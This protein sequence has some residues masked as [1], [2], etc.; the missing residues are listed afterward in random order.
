MREVIVHPTPDVS[1]TVHDVPIPTPGP[2]EII[3]KVHVA[4]SNVKDWLHLTTLN[5]SCNSGDDIAGTVYT[6]GTNAGKSGEFVIGDRVAAFHPMLTDHGAFAEYAV[7]PMHTV[8]KIPDGLEFEEVATIPL[9]IM[10]AGLTLFRRQGLPP[11]WSPR[12]NSDPPT[13]LIIYGAGSA[14]GTFAVK[15]A[16]ASNIH[17]IVAIAGESTSHIRPLLDE[18]LGDRLF[19]YRVG[20]HALKELVDEHLK[21]TPCHHAFDAISAKGTWISVSQMLSPSTLNQKSFLSV[22]SGANK[23]DE[24]SIPEGISIIYTYVGTVHTGAYKASMPKQPL[25]QG[26]V[27]SDPEWAYVFYKYV[28]R[29]L[30]DRRLKGHPFV[31]VEGGLDGVG[32]G[33]RMLKEGKA[34]G[35]KFVFQVAK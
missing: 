32:K 25:D 22:V 10:T 7:A 2:D 34:R 1:A 4:G 8:F 33:L 17:P 14:L 18:D 35:F 24:P 19:D 27:K 21:T 31:V 11:P 3:I 28:S 6:L 26:L 15:L 13:P 16:R 12:S 20:E 29:M 30:A 9:V 23:Y 5:I